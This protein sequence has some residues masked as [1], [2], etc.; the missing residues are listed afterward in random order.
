MGFTMRLLTIFT[1]DAEYHLVDRTCRAV[2]NIGTGHWLNYHP[3][4]GRQL[5]AEVAFTPEDARSRQMLSGVRLTFEGTTWIGPTPVRFVL[6]SNTA[7]RQA[8]CVAA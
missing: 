2:R 3:A 7:P 5:R 1:D 8:D 4:L 6:L